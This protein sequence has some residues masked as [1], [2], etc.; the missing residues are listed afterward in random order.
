M[1]KRSREEEEEGEE[2]ELYESYDDVEG[3]WK[4]GVNTWQIMLF[5]LFHRW[6]RRSPYSEAATTTHLFSHTPIF[7]AKTPFWNVVVHSPPRLASRRA[8]P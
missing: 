2:A 1:A 5:L 8:E 4:V 3:S 6:R 7:N